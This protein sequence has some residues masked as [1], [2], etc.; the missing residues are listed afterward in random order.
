L[1][2]PINSQ[3]GSRLITAKALP[4]VL[5]LQDIQSGVLRPRPSPYAATYILLRI[6]NRKDGREFMRRAGTFVASAA[7]ATSPL[8]DTWVSVALTFQGLKALGVPRDSLESFSPEFQQGM[9]ARAKVLGDTGESSPANW[10]A[11]LGTTDVHIVL[12]AVS[13][14]AHS[15]QAALDRSQNALRD[16]P[17]ITAI[18]RQDCHALA[19]EREAFGFRDGISHPAVEGSGI[20][21]SNSKEQPLKAGEFV[22]GYPDE[23]GAVPS[24]PK[25]D[26]LGR[27]G[28]YVAFRKLQQRV[29]EF[30]R[31]LKANASHLEQEELLAAKMMGRW[32]SGAPLALCPIH[33]NPELGADRRRNNDFLYGDDDPT[34]YK[35]PLGSHAR[36]ANPRDGS[37]AGIVRIHR[38]IRRGTSYGPPLP[39]GVVEDDGIDR[40]LMFAFVGASLARQFEFVQSE[41]INDGSFMG[42]AG[43]RDPI[44]G[45]NDGT[46]MFDVPQRPLRWRLS[47]LARFVVTRGGEYGFMPGLRGLHWLAELKT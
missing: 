4:V 41:W 20:P 33:D 1:L 2:R 23:S 7:H 34:G 46:G 27:N 24:M 21:G 14:D 39:E 18:W 35:T 44:C 15:L 22:L 13:P 26:V 32:R 28:T 16:L 10:E 19:N 37:V 45:P 25:P 36:R 47:G 29:A 5:D 9:A 17:G 40:G 38:M 30:R 42:T 43:A 6:E 12:A 8:R 31:Y 11:P 3:D